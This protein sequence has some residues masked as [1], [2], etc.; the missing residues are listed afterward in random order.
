[1]PYNRKVMDHF[2]SPRNAGDMESA[3]GVGKAAN[4]VDGDVVIVRI[5]VKDGKISEVK[6]QVFGC[7]AAIAGSSAFTE[8]IKG[9]ALE[10]ALKISRQD[11]ADYLGGLPEGK[12][13]CSILGPDALK[14]AVDD[15]NSR[16]R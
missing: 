13:G 8:M 7:A 14:M 9:K 16:N 3:D 12:I 2:M 5:K 1:M 15:Y 6:H 10:D 4:Q 11:V